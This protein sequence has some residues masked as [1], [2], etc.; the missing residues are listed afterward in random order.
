VGVGEVVREGGRE[1]GRKEKKF[2]CVYVRRFFF[3][4]RMNDVGGRECGRMI[5]RE[6][7]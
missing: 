1:G 3:Q 7:A 6:N 4:T 5:E 2:A